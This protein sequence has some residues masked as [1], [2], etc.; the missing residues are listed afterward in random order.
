[1][2]YEV[3]ERIKLILEIQAL[4]YSWSAILFH[5]TFAPVCL[6]IIK[7]TVFFAVS[8]VNTQVHSKCVAVKIYLKILDNSMYV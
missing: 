5:Y 7:K 2:K 4:Y 6:R 3:S 1:M 8:C